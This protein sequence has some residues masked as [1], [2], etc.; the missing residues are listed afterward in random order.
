MQ[1]MK[2]MSNFSIVD[3]EVKKLPIESLNNLTRHAVS[4]LWLLKYMQSKSNVFPNKNK[5][6]QIPR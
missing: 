4:T 6:T 2:N 5:Q 1:N 3:W